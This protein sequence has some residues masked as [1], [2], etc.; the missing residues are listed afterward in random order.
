M[1]DEHECDSLC[2]QYFWKEKKKVKLEN[3]YNTLFIL[4]CY[5]EHLGQPMSVE[6]RK[7]KSKGIN[8]QGKKICLL[9]L[10]VEIHAIYLCFSC[11]V[12]KY[13]KCAFRYFTDILKCIL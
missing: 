8:N 11:S 12:R 1:N 7:K 10:S 5:L 9:H 2:S 3:N 4:S 6:H 13:F